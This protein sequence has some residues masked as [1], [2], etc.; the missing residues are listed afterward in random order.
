MLCEY[1][2][3]IIAL[4]FWFNVWIRFYLPQCIWTLIAMTMKHCVIEFTIKMYWLNTFIFLCAN[5]YKVI[6]N[7]MPWCHANRFVP[8]IGMCLFIYIYKSIFN[9]YKI[10]IFLFF[11]L[12]GVSAHSWLSH[13]FVIFVINHK[14]T[15]YIHIWELWNKLDSTDLFICFFFTSLIKA[16]FII[17]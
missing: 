12:F 9:K 5:W 7:K 13:G 15:Y 6:R 17:S 2:D 14:Y 1:C 11:F 10:R 4:I 16:I 8:I 3:V